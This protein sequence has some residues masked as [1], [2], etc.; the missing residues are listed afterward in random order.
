MRESLCLK[1]DDETTGMS[2]LVVRK[3]RRMPKR[4]TLGNE[5]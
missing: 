4:F 2:L 3:I 5:S 1:T